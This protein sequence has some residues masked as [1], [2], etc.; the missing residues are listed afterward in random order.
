MSP[1]IDFVRED[2]ASQIADIYAPCVR[3]TF[4]S[5]EVEP[6]TPA[7]IRERISK[8]TQQ[9]PWLVVRQ[10]DKVLAYAYASQHRTRAAYQWS[11]DVGIYV[12]ASARRLGIGRRLYHALFQSLRAQ[13]YYNAFAG[14]AL[15]NPASVALHEACGFRPVGVYQNVGFKLGAWRNVGWWQLPLREPNS[16]PTPPISWPEFR[17]RFRDQDIGAMLSS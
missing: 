5:F 13:G 3:E 11:V 12:L 2:D 9:Y 16:T 8:T 14:I 17:K 4:I 7:E 10:D 15:P 1:T 6:P